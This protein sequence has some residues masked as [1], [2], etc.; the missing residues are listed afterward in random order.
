M[1]Y[2]FPQGMIPGLPEDLS[3]AQKKE[4]EKIYKNIKL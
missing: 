2:K 3:E 4:K 1:Q